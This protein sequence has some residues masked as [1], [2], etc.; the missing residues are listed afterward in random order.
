[1]ASLGIGVLSWKAPETLRVTL[2]SHDAGGFA[3][4]FS[5]RLV[6]L[7]E[8]DPDSRAVL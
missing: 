4:L 1:M 6:V 5:E 8:S 7:Q 3:D 2:A